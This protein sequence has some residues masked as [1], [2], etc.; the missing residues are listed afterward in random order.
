MPQRLARSQDEPVPV[1][2]RVGLDDLPRSGANH[3]NFPF[4]AREIHSGGSD[5]YV[6]GVLWVRR[7]L[8]AWRRMTYYANGTW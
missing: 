5:C 8:H 7:F 4:P 1:T 2:A 6:V 3:V